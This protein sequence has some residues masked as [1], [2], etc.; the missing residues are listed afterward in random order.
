MINNLVNFPPGDKNTLD[1]FARYR[2]A[3]TIADVTISY[4]NL[5]SFI[6]APAQ[7]LKRGDDYRLDALNIAKEIPIGIRVQNDRSGRIEGAF[8]KALSDL[9]FR[10]GGNDSRYM[11][12]VNIATSPVEIAGNHNSFTRIELKANLIDTIPGTVL[13]PFDFNSREGHV[14]QAE[15]D[16]RAYSTAE[17]KIN[18]DYPTILSDFLYRSLPKR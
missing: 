2:L 13:L 14:T 16:N 10:S 12:D 9:G 4:G 15:A 1:A 5:V 11:L 8:A 3:A 7:G 18:E 17:R 6:G